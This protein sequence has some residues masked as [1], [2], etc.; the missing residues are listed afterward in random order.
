M[1]LLP[2][3]INCLIKSD[4]LSGGSEISSD[5]R[6]FLMQACLSMPPVFTSAYLY[7]RVISLVRKDF[8]SLLTRIDKL[9]QRTIISIVE[10]HY[11]R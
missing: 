7:P 4:V 11:T 8:F 3:Y 10:N 9:E 5:D 2:L 6:A 1:K